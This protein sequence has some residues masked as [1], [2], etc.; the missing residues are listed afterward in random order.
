MLRHARPLVL[1]AL[2]ALA[3]A[4]GPAF[5][6]GQPPAALE[7]GRHASSAPTARCATR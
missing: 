4:A 7:P 1:A 3:V 6:V 5:G 2:A